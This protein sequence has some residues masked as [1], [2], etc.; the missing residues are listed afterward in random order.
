MTKLLIILLFP[1]LT[2][3]QIPKDKTLHFVAGATISA[4]TYNVVKDITKDERKA[5]VYSLVTPLLIGVAKEIYDTQKK[6][7]T[8]FDVNDLGATVYGGAM[9]TIIIDL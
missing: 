5:K 3:G 1:L 8:G 9:I 2:F 7:P 4:I 6:N